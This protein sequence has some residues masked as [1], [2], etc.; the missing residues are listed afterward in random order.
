MSHDSEPLLL[1][2]DSSGQSLFTSEKMSL[3]QIILQ[4]IHFRISQ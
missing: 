1:E 2:D 4:V 3:C